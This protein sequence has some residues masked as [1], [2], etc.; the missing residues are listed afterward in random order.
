MSYLSVHKM[1]VFVN[2][3]VKMYSCSKFL[4][5][6]S[7]SCVCSVG[8]VQYSTN[9]KAEWHLNS[10]NNKQS[11]LQ[12]INQIQ[13]NIGGTMTGQYVVGSTAGSRHEER[14]DFRV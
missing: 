6:L 11:L 8:L 2:I 3:I 12:A 13:Q 9:P 10:H 5:D 4:F 7:R 1:Q 14:W